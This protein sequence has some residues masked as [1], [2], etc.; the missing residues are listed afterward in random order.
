MKIIKD[1]VAYVQ[2][3]DIVYLNHTDLPIPASIFTKVFGGGIV[4]IDDSNRYEFVEFKEKEEIKFFKKIDWMVDYLEVKDLSEQE[5]IELG[6]RIIEE[7][8]KIADEFNA[9]SDEKKAKN[10]DMVMKYELLQFKL[11]SLRDIL[12]FKQG[13][14]KI[15]LP[16]F[17]EYPEG[18]NK[19]EEKGIKKIIKT[20]FNKK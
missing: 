15:E 19:K 11:Y 20:N 17:I 18:Y 3:N 14:L 12:F 4:I 1:D 10:Q 13:E 8:G 5:I 6:N 7:I 9:M 2:K 16:K